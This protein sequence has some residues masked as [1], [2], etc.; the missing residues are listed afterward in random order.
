[1]WRYTTNVPEKSH[2]SPRRFGG[3]DGGVGD[4]SLFIG[5]SP[6]AKIL[7]S[8]RGHPILTVLTL[9]AHK[10]YPLGTQIFRKANLK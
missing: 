10:T 5:A 8:Y 2:S 4:Y 6:Y 3:M 1:M 7:A 9:L